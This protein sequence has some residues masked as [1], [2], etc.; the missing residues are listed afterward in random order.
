M[1]AEW[2]E[3]F[4][5]NKP[6]YLSAL[7][8]V[9]L[10]FTCVCSPVMNA[11]L[12]VFPEGLA[13]FLGFL[14][15]LFGIGLFVALVVAGF[16]ALFRWSVRAERQKNL[17]G[18]WEPVDPGEPS[19]EFTQDG[20]ILRGDGSAGRYRFADDTIR[21]EIEG[22]PTETLTL[23]T[24]S[25][26]ELVLTG[27]GRTRSYRRGTT[28]QP[29]GDHDS[30][31]G[32][33]GT[34][35]KSRREPGISDPDVAAQVA[36]KKAS[37]RWHAQPVEKKTLTEPEQTIFG[38]D[39]PCP[40]CKTV[41]WVDWQN[42]TVA[43]ACPKCGFRFDHQGAI[44][45]LSAHQPEDNY[46]ADEAA[47]AAEAVDVLE[48]AKALLARHEAATDEAED[49]EDDV[50]PDPIDLICPHCLTPYRGRIRVGATTRCDH[51]LEDFVVCR[52]VP[53]PTTGLLEGLNP[54]SWFASEKCPQCRSAAVNL[55]KAR[56]EGQWLSAD[57]VLH[58]YA[59]YYQCQKCRITWHRSG[60]YTT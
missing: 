23:L 60:A 44:A 25:G 39:G 29:G 57:K 33:K 5:R 49:D 30:A 9:A 4:K 2:L 54:L 46:K 10:L 56:K 12:G 59:W 34:T 50:E 14:Y 55:G 8:A 45:F 1:S 3:R 32:T 27:D 21:I 13:A 7:F 26:H 15:V 17:W 24:I 16:V 40:R 38:G 47:P 28:S 58:A 43:M 51:C 22:R 6:A 52:H 11:V 20:T 37:V 19:L 36:R 42:T 35:V 41:I 18:K 31:L 53:E 48:R